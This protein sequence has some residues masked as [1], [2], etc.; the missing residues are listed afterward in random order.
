MR[1]GRASG[2][3][4]SCIA[5]GCTSKSRVRGSW[6]A[7]RGS[8]N[9]RPH[10]YHILDYSN[11]FCSYVAGVELQHFVNHAKFD[12]SSRSSFLLWRKPIRIKVL[13]LGLSQLLSDPDSVH[14]GEKIS[15]SNRDRYSGGNKSDHV[16]MMYVH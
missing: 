12:K 15:F 2:S 1:L 6:F 10:G 13:H 7:V 4:I 5:P 3:R 14:R 16:S 9:R 11:L 8:P